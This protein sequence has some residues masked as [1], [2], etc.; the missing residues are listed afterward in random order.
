MEANKDLLSDA[1][2]SLGIWSH[3]GK[4]YLDVVVTVENY[5]EAVD[6]AK[7]HNQIAIWDLR[8]NNEIPTGGTG[9]PTQAFSKNEMVK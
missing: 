9:E 5:D 4:T 1:N 6:L 2:N 7:K 8:N 3:E